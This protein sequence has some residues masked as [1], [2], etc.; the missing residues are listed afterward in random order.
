MLA[1]HFGT[2]QG[3]PQGCGEGKNKLSSLKQE[4]GLPCTQCQQLAWEG[5]WK[6][7]QMHVATR[8]GKEPALKP[9]IAAGID[10]ATEHTDTCRHTALMLNKDR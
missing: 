3:T 5:E 7:K 6:S 2:L 8:D 1:A 10:A 4:R 9:G